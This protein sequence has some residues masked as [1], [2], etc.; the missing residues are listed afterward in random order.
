[1]SEIQKMRDRLRN[2]EGFVES[3]A[4]VLSKKMVTFWHTISTVAGAITAL[5]IR[6]YLG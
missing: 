4:V 2:V 6:H 5:I 1:M 3:G